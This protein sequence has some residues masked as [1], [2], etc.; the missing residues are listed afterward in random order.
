MGV[1]S[2]EAV[3]SPVE[4]LALAEQ[5]LAFSSLRRFLQPYDDRMPQQVFSEVAA[6]SAEEFVRAHSWRGDFEYS[7]LMQRSFTRGFIVAGMPP[8]L[9][10]GNVHNDLRKLGKEVPYKTNIARGIA[11]FGL[12]VEFAFGTNPRRYHSVS[13]EFL[14]GRVS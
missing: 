3:E 5:G 1:L 8:Y 4:D 10:A 2:F 6:N 7:G 14:L 13:P 9:V 12:G 11:Y